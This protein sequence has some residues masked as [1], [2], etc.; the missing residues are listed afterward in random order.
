MR[1]KPVYL[2]NALERSCLHLDPFSTMATA[3]VTTSFV[4]NSPGPVAIAFSPD[5]RFERAPLVKAVSMIDGKDST[6]YT[7]GG[8][9][10]A[11]IITLKDKD[12]E[13]DTAT[14]AVDVVTSVAAT[15]SPSCLLFRSSGDS[16]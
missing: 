7:G 4:H 10:L 3:N 13:A 15:V 8:D 14:E 6:I 5:G 2:A 12:A 9:S 16:V 11:R 1:T